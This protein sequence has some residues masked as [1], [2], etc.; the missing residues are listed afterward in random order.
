MNELP[1]IT[2][3]V[4]CRN[5]AEFIQRCLD[6]IIRNEYPHDRMEISVVDGVS[7][8]G[9]WQ[10][11]EKYSAKYAFIQGLRNPQMITPVALNVGIKNST[12]QIIFRVDAHAMLSPDYL[13]LCVEALI[14]SAADNV[15]GTMETLPSTSGIV[16]K[17]IA[18]S[19]SHP[20]GVGNSPFRV[21]RNTAALTDTVFGGCYRRQVFDRIGLFNEKLPRGQDMEF[22][23]RLCNAGGRILLDPHIKNAYYPSPDLKTF[24]RHNLHDGEWAILPFAYSRVVPIRLRHVIPLIFIAALFG[25]AVSGMCSLPMRDLLYGL[26]ASYMALSLL[27]AFQIAMRERDPLLVFLMPLV[28]GIRHVAYGLGSAL[29]IVRLLGKRTFMPH[30]FHRDYYPS[31]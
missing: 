20:F 22:N 21:S 27:S 25:L 24:W 2:V 5:E 11:I 29:G 16:A 30:L 17:A 6:S 14:S 10:I 31:S 18:M 15:G 13:R 28:F 7:E 26:V 9:T 1:K 4:P 8:D 23:R 19:I 12:G 3:I